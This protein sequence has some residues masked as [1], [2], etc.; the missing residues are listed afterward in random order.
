MKLSK[1][2]EKILT[3]AK[4]KIDFARSCNTYEEYEYKHNY[5]WKGRYTLEEA[6]AKILEHDNE[7]DNFYSNLYEEYKKGKALVTANSRTIEKL[8]ELGLIKVID[9]GG[10]Y[11]DL[12]EVI[13]Y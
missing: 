5:Y 2:Q 6:R 3:D 12:I 11:P 1:A 7:C 13:G 10:S 8:E 9:I 4:A